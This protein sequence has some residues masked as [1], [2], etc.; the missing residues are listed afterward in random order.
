MARLCRQLFGIGGAAGRLIL[1]PT[2]VLEPEV[3]VENFEAYVQ[4][5]REA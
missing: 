5:A 2:H 3:P 4:A 1:G